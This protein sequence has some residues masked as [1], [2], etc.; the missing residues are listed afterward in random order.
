MR[1]R[2][3]VVLV[4]YLQVVIN[5]EGVP[6]DKNEF[7]NENANLTSSPSSSGRFSPL[8]D[9]ETLAT[10][11]PSPT[12]ERYEFSPTLSV[13]SDYSPVYSPVMDDIDDDD[14]EEEYE[15]LSIDDASSRADSPFLPQVCI[16]FCKIT[17]FI[18]DG[19]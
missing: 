12:S 13:N 1:Q 18:F 19:C 9:S 11:S 2:L 8:S 5:N 6:H 16:Y 15:K 10:V 3:I 4:S 14:Q 7:K 17:V